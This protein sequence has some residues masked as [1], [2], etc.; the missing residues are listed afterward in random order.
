MRTERRFAL[1]G[2]PSRIEQLFASGSPAR[3]SRGV[4][5]YRPPP[6]P[7]LV[8]NLPR[9]GRGTPGR[10]VVAQRR[11]AVNRCPCLWWLPGPRS[12]AVIP[13]CLLPLGKRAP[14]VWARYQARKI[15]RGG[16]PTTAFQSAPFP[17]GRRESAGRR[18]VFR[19]EAPF[20]VLTVR[21]GVFPQRRPPRWSRSARATE[22]SRSA[23]SV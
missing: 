23:V 7:A 18:D 21:S 22:A 6:S 9:A 3:R 2:T 15:R 13:P 8:G 17:I 5:P 12:S 10:G 14:S 4:L 16:K 11:R 19:V 20:L 1:T